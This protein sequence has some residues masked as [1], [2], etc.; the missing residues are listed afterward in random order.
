MKAI[1]HVLRGVELAGAYAQN[2]LILKRIDS[3]MRDTV[4]SVFNAATEDDQ[5]AWRRVR[6]VLRLARVPINKTKTLMGKALD[7]GEAF[8]TKWGV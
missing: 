8:V 6:C 1:M 2:Q 3:L 5:A 7:N 4:A